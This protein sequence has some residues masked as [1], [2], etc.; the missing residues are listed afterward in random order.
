MSLSKFAPGDRVV[1]VGGVLMSGAPAGVYVVTRV[2]PEASRTRQYRVKNA[3]ENNERVF[4]EGQL[5]A[6]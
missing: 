3:A 5:R 1:V 4:E 6:A 2:M